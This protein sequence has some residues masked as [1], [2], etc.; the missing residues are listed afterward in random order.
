MAQAGIPIRTEPSV[1]EQ[2]LSPAQPAVLVFETPDC[3][4]CRELVP[5]LD[6]LAAEF[7]NRLRVIRVEDSGEGWVA[8]RYHL[9]FVPTLLLLSGGGE[10]VRLRGNPGR[11]GLF[12]WVRFMLGDGPRPEVV[13]G[14]RYTLRAPFRACCSKAAH[15]G[16]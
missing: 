16:A 1:I 2:W 13:E 6:A 12:A 15:I 11:D 9:N 5:H 3:G 7:V 8:A 10:V 14:P 4:P